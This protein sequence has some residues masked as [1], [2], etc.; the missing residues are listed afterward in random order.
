FCF[1][2]DLYGME[3]DTPLPLKL[4]V[5]LTPHGTMILVPRHWSPD[6]GRDLHW[7]K[8]S[9]VHRA[10]GAKRQGPNWSIGRI[11]FREKAARAEELKAKGKKAGLRGEKLT[12]FVLEGLNSDLRNGEDYLKRLSRLLR[13]Q[14]V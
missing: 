11:E 5:N 12:E 7:K 3:W 8:I 6:F 9:K 4:S 1:R 14:A 10:H 2:W 13:K